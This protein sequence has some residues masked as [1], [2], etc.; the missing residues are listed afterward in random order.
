MRLW[1]VIWAA[2]L[3]VL[4]LSCGGATEDHPP[5][6]GPAGTRPA[7]VQADVGKA[8]VGM[9]HAFELP[10]EVAEAVYLGEGPLAMNTSDGDGDT[11]PRWVETLD[12]NG[13][14][15][16]NETQLIWD[17]EDDMLFAFAIETFDCLR[18]AGTAE[19]GMLVVTYGKENTRG[20]PPGSGFWLVGLDAGEC[21]S[22]TATL[23][24]CHFDENG[25]KTKCGEGTIDVETG[26]LDIT[27]IE[28]LDGP[29]GPNGRRP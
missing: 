9:V 11:D 24:G 8:V 20:A 19:G 3:P 7:G 25:V 27:T 13:N 29:E 2:A 14:G 5:E 21:D 28:P 22:E 23:W 16:M 26:A 12:I 10:T 4:T 18:G 15:I 6:A 1:R 17:D